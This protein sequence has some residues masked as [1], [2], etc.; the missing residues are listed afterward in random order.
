[1]LRKFGYLSD[2]SFVN[3]YLDKLQ[4]IFKAGY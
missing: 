1:M 4:I 2:Y 3:G